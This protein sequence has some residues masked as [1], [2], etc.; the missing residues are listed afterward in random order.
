MKSVSFRTVEQNSSKFPCRFFPPI[1]FLRNYH[2]SRPE[3]PRIPRTL[4]SQRTSINIYHSESFAVT[5][6]KWS[7]DRTTS[8]G[9]Y[10]GGT[11]NVFKLKKYRKKNKSAEI[12]IVF[13]ECINNVLSATTGA[14]GKRTPPPRTAV[15]RTRNLII[16]YNILHVFIVV[17]FARACGF[18]F[19]KKKFYFSYFFLGY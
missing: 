6:N 12:T 2:S 8:G 4:R 14:V 18:F 10:A 13:L 3:D 7:V 19:F 16:S 1:P 15:N 17:L 5:R 9:A 11:S